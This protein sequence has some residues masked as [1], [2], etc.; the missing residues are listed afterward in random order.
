M[1]KLIFLFLIVF[2]SQTFAQ[3]T[4]SPDSIPLV[5]GKVFFCVDFNTNLKKDTTRE[6]IKRYLNESLDPYAGEFN[7]DNEDFTV[8]R[9]TDYIDVNSGIL[10]TFAMYMTY[11]LSF[12][13]KDSLCVMTIQNIS[14][15]DKEYFETKEERELTGSRV[16][17]MPEYTAEDI[18]IHKKYK[19]VMVGNASKKITTSSVERIN[20]I[21]KE[22]EIRLYRK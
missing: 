17:N 7:I 20:N 3:M 9:I 5:E 10:N 16:L 21:I 18:M 13:Y 19:L 11:S 15:M 14:Y 22:I 1:K 2:S 8:C 4:F 12:E 6:R